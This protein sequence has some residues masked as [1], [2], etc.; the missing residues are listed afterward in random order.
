M[1]FKEKVVLVTGGARGIGREIAAAFAG[2]ETQIALEDVAREACVKTA[3]E[4]SGRGARVKGYGLDVSSMASCEETAGQML[5][6]FGRVDVL[7]NNAGITRDNL[8]IR[9][10]EEDFDRVVTINLKGTFICT[11]IFARI[12]MKQRA[13]SIINIA[14]V[15]GLTGNAGQVNYAA[16]KAGILGVTKSAAKELAS[17]NIRVNAIAPGFIQTDMTEEL[18][19]EVRKAFLQ[20][21]ALKRPGT[22]QDVA[23]AA[24]F[25]ASE[26][27]SYITGQVLVVDG[28]MVM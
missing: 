16:S 17:R 28:G 13:G 19:E 9:M 5:E 8:L 25:L 7:V 23:N 14:S 11:R 26:Y 10:S 22:P 20:N 27:A 3:E 1:D 21:I 18:S 4:L 15:V 6:D 2:H 12:M 24:L